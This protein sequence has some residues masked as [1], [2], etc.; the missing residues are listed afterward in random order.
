MV[1]D[2]AS[3]PIIKVVDAES[4]IRVDISFNTSNGVDSAKLILVSCVDMLRPLMH[5]TNK[6][7]S[8]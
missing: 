1:L 5:G 6:S 3:V 2:R 8:H 4:N 7:I